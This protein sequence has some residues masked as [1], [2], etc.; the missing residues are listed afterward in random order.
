MFNNYLVKNGENIKTI[1]SKFN[2]SPQELMHI[3]NLYFDSDL[4]AGM[5]II[6]TK[7]E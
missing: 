5:E 4:R 1:A 3:N 7:N 2:V 6:L